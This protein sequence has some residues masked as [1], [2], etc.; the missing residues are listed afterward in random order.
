MMKLNMND[1]V[2]VKLTDIGRRLHKKDHDKF[3]SNFPEMDRSQ[4]RPPVEDSEG[5]SKWQ[6]WA[7]MQSFGKYMHLGCKVPF[8]AE[9]EIQEPTIS[10]TDRA[11]APEQ[12]GL[13]AIAKFLARELAKIEDEMG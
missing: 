5:R 11:I 3:W 1:Y 2:L 10:T 7:L 6:M 12:A 9:I 8:E 4:Y 13:N